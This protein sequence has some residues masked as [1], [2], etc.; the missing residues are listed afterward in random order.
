VPHIHETFFLSN[1]GKGGEHLQKK[2]GDSLKLFDL[3]KNSDKRDP[4]RI[5][6]AKKHADWKE[7]MGI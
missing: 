1:H 7:F 3:F 2:E 4:I 5:Y 6:D